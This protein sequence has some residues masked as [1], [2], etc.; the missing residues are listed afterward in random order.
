VLQPSPVQ[1]GA[2][3]RSIVAG[4]DFAC[5]LDQSNQAWCWGYRTSA[6]GLG[7]PAPGDTED[8]VAAPTKVIGAP[9]LVALAAG[10]HHVCGVDDS[11]AAWCW[12]DGSLGQ[13][14]LPGRPAGTFEEVHAWKPVKVGGDHGFTSIAA[15]ARHTCA[16]DGDGSAW[17]WGSSDEGQLGD[18]GLGS[19]HVPVKV[20]GGLVF[21]SIA[22]GGDQTCGLGADGAAYCWGSGY[23]GQLGY[24]G[25]QMRPLPVPVASLE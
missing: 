13:V 5:G 10:D 15:G 8:P 11:G 20:L 6:L 16:V 1:G 14:G 25:L 23:S 7:E 4:N 17:C 21:R 9:A 24:G 3:F 22:A 18:G 12:G 2:S 19:S